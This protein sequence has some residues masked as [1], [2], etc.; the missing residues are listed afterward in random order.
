MTIQHVA[1]HFHMNQETTVSY[2]IVLDVGC[3][4]YDIGEQNDSVDVIIKYCIH[5][6]VYS[7]V[8]SGCQEVHG[9]GA[10]ERVYFI[11]ITSVVICILL[12]G[13]FDPNGLTYKILN[14]TRKAAYCIFLIL[15][16][17]AIVKK[18]KTSRM[19]FLQMTKWMQRKLTLHRK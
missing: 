17:P 8:T 4:Q 9:C 16:L 15:K 14:N 1:T 7:Y 3:R 10:G 13:H 18:K 5:S 11:Y 19:I 12:N 2:D 6:G